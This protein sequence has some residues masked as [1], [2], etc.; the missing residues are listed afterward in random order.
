VKRRRKERK[1]KKK[2]SGKKKIRGRN[3]EHSQMTEIN[4]RYQD[5]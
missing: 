5:L 1:T 4:Y 3:K 2:E